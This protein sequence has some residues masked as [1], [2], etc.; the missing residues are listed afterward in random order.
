[1]NKKLVLLVLL[2]IP[3]FSYSQEQRRVQLSVYSGLFKAGNSKEYK[4]IQPGYNLGMGLSCFLDEHFF[5]TA[6]WNYGQNSYY[7]D[8]PSITKYPDWSLGF[9][10]GTNSVLQLN[11]IGLLARY[12]LP[13]TQW[14]NFKG[15]I[16]ISQI[17]EIRKGFP[18]V[19][20]APNLFLGYE[21]RT[22]SYSST[23][24]ALALPVKFDMGFTPFKQAR[25]IELGLAF[26]FYIGISTGAYVSP[27]IA[28]S[29]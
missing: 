20:Y 3:L 24:F 13:V 11:N 12:Y 27:Q 23:L 19:L 18:L 5:L 17:I 8:C 28:I 25:N 6:H 21:L 9:P 26:G 29:F 15:Q 2:T 4:R 16:G 1:M 7:E 14:M 10:G 22:G